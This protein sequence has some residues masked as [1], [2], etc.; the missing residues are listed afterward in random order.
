M[1]IFIPTREQLVSLWFT[2]EEHN[3]SFWWYLNI[4][5]SYHIEY[6]DWLAI[7]K[8]WMN[9]INVESSEDI[10]TLIRLLTF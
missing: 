2:I 9:K 1:E 3:G 5:W 8:L 6:K 7:W 4:K 10:R